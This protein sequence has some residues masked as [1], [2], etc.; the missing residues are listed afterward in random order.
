MI[1]MK[2]SKLM[3][4]ETPLPLPLHTLHQTLWQK[5]D[6]QADQNDLCVLV[7]RGERVLNQLNSSQT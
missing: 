7:W 6:F 2:E 1:V 5:D 4:L 3:G